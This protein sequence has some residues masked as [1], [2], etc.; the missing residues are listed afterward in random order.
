MQPLLY[1]Q[2]D[3][4]MTKR[5]PRVGDIVIAQHPFKQ[6]QLIKLVETIEP[7]GCW[8]VGMNPGESTDSRTLGFFPI[9]SIQGVVTSRLPSVS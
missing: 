9:D 6:V 7:A 4:L 3:V 2:D 1:A 8:L 5:A